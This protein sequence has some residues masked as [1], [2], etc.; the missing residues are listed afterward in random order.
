MFPESCQQ[1]GDELREGGSSSHQSAAYWAPKA[2]PDSVAGA[3]DKQNRPEPRFWEA[4]KQLGKTDVT[5]VP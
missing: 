4:S 2:V 3:G 1:V 5:S